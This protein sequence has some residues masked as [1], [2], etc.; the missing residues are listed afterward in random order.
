M[1]EV[2]EAPVPTAE[3]QAPTPPTTVRKGGSPART[4]N[5]FELNHFDDDDAPYWTQIGSVVARNATN[6][7]RKAFREFKG[8]AETDTTLVAVPEGMWRPT[9]VRGRRRDDITVSIG[10]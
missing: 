5:V 7:L 10:E 4:Y 2:A 1:P 8:A 3:E 9:L 6:A